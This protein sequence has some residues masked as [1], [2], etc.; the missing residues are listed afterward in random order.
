MYHKKYLKY[1]E[2]YLNLKEHFNQSGG[3]MIT[4]FFC[5]FIQLFTGKPCESCGELLS[6]QKKAQDLLPWQGDPDKFT[7]VQIYVKDAYKESDSSPSGWFEARYA[8]KNAFNEFILL[9]KPVYEYKDS[10]ENITIKKLPNKIIYLIDHKYDKEPA[11]YPIANLDEVETY[12][13]G[14]WRPAISGFRWAYFDFVLS[15]LSEIGY[16]SYMSENVPPGYRLIKLKLWPNI[17]FKMKKNSD[18]TIYYEENE[19]KVP[20][21]YKDWI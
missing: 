20:I 9:Q 13:S 15:N 8:Y 4:C 14:S 2:K 19:R 16:Y 3:N 17:I 7:G 1:K 10:A 21:R 11:E 6:K 12:G 5:K 18:G